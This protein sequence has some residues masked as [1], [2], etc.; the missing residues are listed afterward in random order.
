M[1]VSRWAGL[2][3]TQAELDFVDV[4]PRRDTRLFVDPYAI[5]IRD[6]AWSHE[7]GQHI[8]SFFNSLL[9][10]LRNGDDA[11]ATHLASHLHEAGETYLGLSRGVPQGRGVGPEQAERIIDALRQSRAF[12]TGVLADLGETE[13]FVEGIGP[14]KISDL[15]TNVIRGP[16]L[17]Y[18]RKQAELWGM[19]LTRRGDVGAI[20][21]PN[22]EEWHQDFRNVLVVGNQP[23]ILVPKVS[24]RLRLSLNSQEFYNHH[25]I[26]YLQAEY[27][28]AGQ[29]LVRTLKSGE[30][31]VYKTDVKD[32]HPL[33]KPD[34][35]DF[36]NQHPEVLEHY[37]NI[38]GAQGALENNDIER[39][40][41]EGEH[42]EALIAEIEALPSG[43]DNAS[44]YHK[45]CLAALTFLFYPNLIS[46]VKEREID[47]GRKRIDI[48]YVNAARDGFFDVA[49]K[50]AQMR[51]VEIVVECKNYGGDIANPELD[52]IANR[53]SH[54]RGFL[55]I[56]CSRAFENKQRFIERCK[57]A[58]A[59][60]GQYVLPLDDADIIQMLRLVAE[61]QRA[62]IDAVLRNRYREISG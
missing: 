25:M 12:Q 18:T 47:Q 41:R 56:L 49:L 27:L 50:S 6:D 28:Q 24:V 61:G 13:L 14:D 26:N 48:T 45:F 30:K 4:D 8:R 16:L 21:D 32:R 11:R 1:K 40:F 23:V 62:R 53:F 36:V 31:R 20:W 17:E 43:N 9:Q 34:L 29:A 35:A 54:V 3:R 58:A 60:R 5:E 39:D 22:R 59:H 38:K 57:D 15:T 19:P 55:G 51:A 2:R 33:R 42:A 44:R 46:P 37:K 7:C 10:A 52:Q